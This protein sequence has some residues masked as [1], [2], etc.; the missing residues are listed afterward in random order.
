[1]WAES[2]MLRDLLDA[3]NIIVTDTRD[4]STWQLK[5]GKSVDEQGEI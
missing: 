1:M 4:A 5:N 3:C 2:D